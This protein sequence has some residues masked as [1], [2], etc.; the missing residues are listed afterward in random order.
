MTIPCKIKCATTYLPTELSNVIW[1]FLLLY[2]ERVFMRNQARFGVLGG[3]VTLTG[4]PRRLVWKRKKLLILFE[5]SVGTSAEKKVWV[6]GEVVYIFL[7]VSRHLL[8]V[9]KDVGGEK[10]LRFSPLCQV[11]SSL[12]LESTLQCLSLYLYSKKRRY[13]FVT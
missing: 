13:R 2:F 10:Y 4:S 7:D 12:Y 3:D 6:R 5:I 11:C 9:N 8:D 1:T